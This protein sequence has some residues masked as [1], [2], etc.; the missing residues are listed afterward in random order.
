MNKV[1]ELRIKKGIQAKQLALEIG[2]SNATVSDWEHGRKNPTGERLRRLAE[3]FNVDEGYILGY[4]QEKTNSSAP[5]KTSSSVK[6]EA[7]Q[8]ID[9]LLEQLDNQPRTPE[10][11]IL[12]KGVDKLS[13]EQREQALAVFRVVFANHAEDFEKGT[14]NDDA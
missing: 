3:F 10:A 2:V 14:I 5:D 6:T 12:A 9:R 4:G 8:I 7:E 13:Q 1:R 11:K